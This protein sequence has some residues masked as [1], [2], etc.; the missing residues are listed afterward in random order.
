MEF[1]PENPF[2]QYTD[3]EEDTRP[4][5]WSD[6][7]YDERHDYI[8]SLIKLYKQ[9]DLH[10]AHIFLQLQVGLN[11]SRCG[12]KTSED[13][14]LFS[15]NLFSVTQEDN[16]TR[17]N[18]AWS[19]LQRKL[20]DK[21]DD[22]SAVVVNQSAYVVG[23]EFPDVRGLMHIKNEVEVRVFKENRANM[24]VALWSTQCKDL[25]A[26]LEYIDTLAHEKKVGVVYAINVD[27]IFLYNEAIQKV[28]IDKVKTTFLRDTQF[29]NM[30]NLFSTRY[31]RNTCSAESTAPFI[32]LTDS[33]GKVA[34]SQP[35]SRMEKIESIIANI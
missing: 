15:E 16:V 18:S 35:V 29:S 32:I 1:Q 19:S 21:Y 34:F 25:P 28:L 12:V 24:L 33:T 4:K 17:F 9:H 30:N 14:F 8:E 23:D 13:E 11:L 26:F 27:R 6:C 5:S 3:K 2:K 31:L 22:S 20:S 7:T 10:S